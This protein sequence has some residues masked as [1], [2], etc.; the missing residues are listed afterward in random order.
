M[1]AAIFPPA[2]LLFVLGSSPGL[3]APKARSVRESLQAD[4]RAAFD[5]ATA[6]YARGE[7]LQ[8]RQGFVRAHDASS[9]PRVLY[10]VAVCDKALGRYLRAIEAL[11]I[12]LSAPPGSLPPSYVQRVQETIAVLEAKLARVQVTTSVPA[13][14][15]LDGEPRDRS[16]PLIA[17]PG[18][19]LLEARREGH[20]EA[21]Q[22]IELGEGETKQVLLTMQAVE[23]VAPRPPLPA[24]LQIST[25]EARDAVSVDG[26]RQAHHRVRLQLSPG[27]H[28][29]EVRRPDAG[30]REID[31]VLRAGET[32]DLR[33]TLPERARASHWPLVVA[34]AGAL[35]VGGV[36]A[37]TLVLT[38]T[39]E[40]AGANPGVLPPG[41]VTA[42]FS[43][44]GLQ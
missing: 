15:F 33:I 42:G 44:P 3:A 14:I 9:D 12:S 30:T 17:D 43:P 11:R 8:A 19:H 25:G 32:R 13:E 10:N 24:T 40:Y 39:T 27:E 34:G 5:E 16:S 37:T 29:V 1:R 22:R 26:V 2:I 28:R 41:V 31:L 4:A 35:L 20:R 36:L 6:D 7:Y 38:R 18:S 21:R 23:S